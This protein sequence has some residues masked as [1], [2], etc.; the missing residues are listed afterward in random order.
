MDVKLEWIE[1]D[2]CRQ[3]IEWMGIE[4]MRIEWMGIEW[5]GIKLT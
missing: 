3:G 1:L 4:W 2:E 5:M